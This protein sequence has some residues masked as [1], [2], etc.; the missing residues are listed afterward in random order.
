MEFC[1]SSLKVDQY[2]AISTWGAFSNRVAAA[3]LLLCCCVTWSV[4][5]LSPAV[6]GRCQWGSL[7]AQQISACEVRAGNSAIQ[8]ARL[9]SI[10]A[11]IHRRALFV[12]LIDGLGQL[13]QLV[14][15]AR[16]WL[17]TRMSKHHLGEI[18][19]CSSL[20]QRS[21][22]NDVWGPVQ[23]LLVAGVS[24]VTWACSG[25]SSALCKVMHFA[26]FAAPHTKELCWLVS[27][28]SVCSCEQ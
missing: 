8:H 16:M 21:K 12:R 1:L 28:P 24:R 5:C 4:K 20:S 18:V 19:H 10:P 2:R 7:R 23:L 25:L 6:C 15:C 3:W 13:R 14:K 9:V 22:F 26:G 11:H 17:H 27:S